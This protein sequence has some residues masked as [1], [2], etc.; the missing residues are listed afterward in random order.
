[1][2]RRRSIVS[3]ALALSVMAAGV[4]ALPARSH[5]GLKDELFERYGFGAWFVLFSPVDG[6]PRQSAEETE[7]AEAAAVG[8]A[9]TFGMTNVG[10]GTEPG[11]PKFNARMKKTVWGRYKSDK[12]RHVVIH[13]F[14]SDY[15]TALAVHTGEKV[16]KLKT[17]VFN[18]NHKVAG[19]SNTAS[20]VKFN[21]KKGV[22]Y[23]VQIGSKTGD[24]GDVYANVSVF[25]PAGG[26]TAHLARVNAAPW[27]GRDY[28]CQAGRVDWPSCG[29]PT[30]LLHNST[31]KTVKVTAETDL[32]PAF[33]APAPI[34]LKPGEAKTAAFAVDGLD[35]ATARTVAGHF[36]FTARRGKKI[37]REA[38]VRGLVVVKP[39]PTQ[40]NVL[41]AEVI[42]HAKAGYINEAHAFKVRLVNTGTEAARGCHARSDYAGYVAGRTAVGW[43]A[44]TKSGKPISAPNTPIAIP[45]KKAKWLEVWVASQQSRVGDVT[46]EIPVVPDLVIDCNNT[47]PVAFDHKNRF[48]I[49]ARG[50]W[51]PAKVT[52]TAVAP[53]GDVLV[54][55]NKGATFRVSALNDGAEAPL[56]AWTK[57]IR[58]YDESDPD[59][60]FAVSI[61]RTKTAKSKCLAP[62][63]NSV[64][65]VAQK[66]A[67]SHFMVK[68]ER[69]KKDPG[70]D[71]A[72]R[73]VFLILS[74]KKPDGYVGTS[75]VAVAAHSIAPR[76][77]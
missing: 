41:E 32:D 37:V 17:V 38:K 21:A 53:K 8:Q 14:G 61:C 7:L 68:V 2:D 46:L 48:D 16:N 42:P 70:F 20:L 35:T 72:L 23:A 59:K 45:A 5:A 44:V 56:V 18:D 31:N 60:Q 11:E 4:T 6:S 26:L 27:Q 34:T 29:A 28:V 65:L 57:Y 47:A 67:R 62:L 77:K 71:P 3:I 33:T 75:R 54:V 40:P 52:T 30:F 24:E 55:P 63:A 74:H 9:A 73:R 15:D 10:A 69:P 39:G 19:L 50:G 49:T 12:N 51:Q 66:G 25:P 22:E 76:R 64:D 13:T 58:P 1:M 36:A 43:R